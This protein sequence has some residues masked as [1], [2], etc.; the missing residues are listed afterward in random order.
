M[1]PGRLRTGSR[2]TRSGRRR[3]W[4]TNTIT[5]DETDQKEATGKCVAFLIGAQATAVLIDAGEAIPNRAVSAGGVF[6]RE[7]S[8]RVRR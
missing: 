7:G 5:V 6:A 3:R 2:C 1:M 4:R 8:D